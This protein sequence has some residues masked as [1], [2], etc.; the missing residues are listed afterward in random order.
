M[1][2]GLTR[3][4]GDGDRVRVLCT[5]EVFEF[6]TTKYTGSDDGIREVSYLGSEFYALGYGILT[7]TDGADWTRQSS[8]PSDNWGI[9]AYG[10]GVFVA[11]TV[12]GSSTA[13]TS[14]LT[15]VDGTTWTPRW[16]SESQFNGLAHLNGQFL[17]ATEFGKILTSPDGVAWTERHSST[18]RMYSFAW[19][20]NTYVAAGGMF[21]STV[22]TSPDSVTWTRRTVPSGDKLYSVAFGNNLFVA[23]GGFNNATLMTSPDGI[24]WATR[25]SPATGLYRAVI[26]A[27]GLF[28]AAGS[29]GYIATSPDGINWTT[30]KAA[31]S[32]NI[33]YDLN[34]LE[35]R[36][37]TFFAI[38]GRT[39]V[40]WSSLDAITWTQQPSFNS[41][42]INALAYGNGTFLKTGANAT[43]LTAVDAPEPA[44]LTATPQS[45]TRI[46]LSWPDVAGETGYTIDRRVGANGAWT[47]L[48]PSLPAGST[49]YSDTTGQQSVS[50]SYRIRSLFGSIGSRYSAT[51]SASTFSPHEAWR[52][53]H[54][55]TSA[56]TGLAAD[57]ADPDFDGILNLVELAL[58]TDPNNGAAIAQPGTSI[59]AANRLAV[60]FSRDA[61]FTN[62]S[63][64]V[65][66][67]SD[68]QTW[69]TIAQSVGGG[70]TSNLSAF[71]VE[72]EGIG[73]T[74]FRVTVT[75]PP[76]TG[77]HQ[78]VRVKVN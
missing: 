17:A 40:L 8:M 73:G 14:I 2:A 1:D 29:K 57:D 59:D 28:V 44:N 61:Q 27:N 69:T 33:N 70:P 26:F 31:I 53:A 18:D 10:N 23:V 11:A 3:H 52:F 15:S 72:E 71:A 51:A 75:C 39:G 45:A 62:I 66:T 6:W 77:G 60:E 46:D 67:S 47:V 24:T 54:F 42:T 12:W 22:L 68:L 19:G 36:D 43:I 37:G 65:Q 55:G 34:D 76:A 7:S 78:F 74:R 13:G 64:L 41:Y 21:A 9:A 58:G 38:E 35:F 63:Y 25:N 30:R 49:A 4:W 56:N 50:Y 16:N 32:G 48:A 5:D 20:N